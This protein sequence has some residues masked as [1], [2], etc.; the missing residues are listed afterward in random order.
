LSAPLFISTITSKKVPE[1]I[2]KIVTP[3]ETESTEP[4]SVRI[5]APVPPP[6]PEHNFFLLTKEEECSLN[7]RIQE[8]PNINYNLLTPLAPVVLLRP[9]EHLLSFAEAI[10]LA[11]GEDYDEINFL[12]NLSYG[13]SIYE[14]LPAMEKSYNLKEDES[15]AIYFYTLEWTPTS[16]NLYSR[17]NR[18]LSSSERERSV[19]PWKHYL[20]YLFSGLRKIP[21]VVLKQDLYRGINQNVIKNYPKKY[22]VG[23]KITWYGFTSTTTN[24][25]KVKN[26]I[27]KSEGTV[28]VIN[29][30]FSGRL[31]HNFSGHSEESEVILPAGSRFE[32]VGVTDFGDK[33]TFIQL[34]QENS[35][36]KLLMME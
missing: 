12:S 31:I 30:C 5:P 2:T 21:K 34:K 26:F 6:N 18:D 8:N 15:I 22:T 10:K 36:E 7:P 14:N 28:F 3:D 32:I 27:G 11:Y 35:L 9:H 24:F 17:L 13:K 19:P 1:E 23:S 25:N 29:G 33:L 16:Q 20:H 4:S